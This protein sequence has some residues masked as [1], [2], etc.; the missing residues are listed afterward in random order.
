MMNQ[1][2]DVEKEMT[3]E[4][5]YCDSRC[6]DSTR[7]EQSL[8]IEGVSIVFRPFVI[9]ILKVMPSFFRSELEHMAAFRLIQS[10]R[11]FVS[12]MGVI[13]DHNLY[14]L[15]L[16]RSMLGLRV[17]TRRLSKLRK[18]LPKSKDPNSEG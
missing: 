8:V 17:S 6:I 1:S 11:Q 2:T 16:W 5:V 14:Q 9:V 3:F 13:T 7:F 18:L 12:E 10:R 15:P 4:S